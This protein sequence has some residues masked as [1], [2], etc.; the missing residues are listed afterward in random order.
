MDAEL[1]GG[2][3]YNV[4]TQSGGTNFAQPNLWSIVPA[5]QFDTAVSSSNFGKPIILGTF[6][7]AKS[8]SGTFTTTSTNVSWGALGDTGTGTFTI[9]RLTM[10]K[11][12][13]AKITGDVSSSLAS[14]KA[15]SLDLVNGKPPVSVSTISGNVFNDSNANAKLDTGEVGLSGWTI[16]IDK[17]GDGKLNS[18][19]LKAIT[20]SS[21]N[22][23]FT[24]FETGTY[25]VHEVVPVG[26]RRTLPSK[27]SY[28]LAVTGGVN[29]TGLNWGNTTRALASGTVFKD[30]NGNKKFDSG[31][32]GAPGM[33][34]FVDANKDGV[35]DNGEASCTTDANGFWQFKNLKAGTYVV[36]IQS[37]TGYKI[38]TPTSF[39]L[40]VASAALSTGHNNFGVKK[41]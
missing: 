41:S 10:S 9:A 8:G 21:G 7:P 20:N 36:R 29:V 4:P 12:A 27:T 6:N 32:P 26:Y 17:N 19:E 16:Y 13:T 3:F 40:T 18:G 24:D 33:I 37:R 11:G 31:E 35:L 28:S 14:Q 5:M 22:Y 30:N 2:T 34:V 15:F 38:T 39:S 1:T 25:S 23:T